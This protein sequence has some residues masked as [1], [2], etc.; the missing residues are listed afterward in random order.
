MPISAAGWNQYPDDWG[1]ISH[2]VKERAGWRCECTG[3]CGRGFEH[4][5]P[6]DGRCRNRHGEPRWRGRWFQGPVFLAAA[7]L[8][9]DPSGT[10]LETIFALCEGCHL[11]V[12][13]GQH[14]ATRRA[15]RERIL[16]LV[17]LFELA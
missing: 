10:D 11:G 1:V 3:E 4:L 14:A 17:P 2:A 8:D 6:V 13:R 16:G 15:N 5:E 12:D 9:H 7:H